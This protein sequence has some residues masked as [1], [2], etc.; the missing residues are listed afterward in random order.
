MADPAQVARVISDF[1]TAHRIPHRVSCRA[2]GVS[3]SWFYTHRTRRP[4]RREVRR[5]QLAEAVQEKFTDSGGTYGSPKIW[6]RLVRQGRRVSVNTIAKIMS[7]FG[8][9]ARRCAD[10]GAAP[11]WEGPAAPDFVLRDFT[12]ETPDLVW[13]GDMTEIET[14][15]GKLYLATVIDLLSRRLL[16]YAIAARH[17]AELVVAALHI[18]VATRGG[19][20]RGA[21]FHTDRDS[22][23]ASRRFRRARRRLGVFQSTGRVGTCFDNAV[24]EA[25]NSMLKAEY[26][27]RHTFT[28]RTE[29][30]IR[31]STWI[32]DFNNARRL[33]SACGFQNP[34]DYEHDYQA[35]LTEELAA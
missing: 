30:R 31:I 1:R 27:H 19:N 28:T 35:S 21:I 18:A 33:H 15:E 7:E 26:V 3:E 25:S 5:Q 9:V 12:A 32:T 29:A 20:V 4:T 16:S 24:S 6:I 34:I 14:G 23:Y 13:C 10:G 11:A 17:D 22:E 2:P 8:L